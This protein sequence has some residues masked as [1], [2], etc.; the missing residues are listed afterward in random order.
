[1]N[2]Y[3]G[4]NKMTVAETFAVNMRQ[5]RLSLGITQKQLGQMLGYSEKSVSKWESGEA[6][7]PSVL[8]PALAGILRISI[9]DLFYSESEPLYYLGIDGGGTKTEFLLVDKSGAEI[10]SIIL[11]ES[12]PVDVGIS[13]TFEVLEKG[14]Y[15]VC[16][17]VP[18]NKVSVF[19]GVAG[20]ITG[21]NQKK[22]AAFLESFHFCKS[23]NDSDAKNAVVA[24][25]EDANGIAVILG[26]G[27]IAFTQNN[28]TFY[29]TGGFGYLFD[30]GGSGY[31]I[32]RDAIL[33][34]LRAEEQGREETVLSVKLKEHYKTDSLLGH[35]SELYE[36]S[37]KY[38]ASAV[39]VVFDAFN[40]GDETALEILERNFEAVSQLIVDASRD[41]EGENVRVC[42]VG[43]LS[44]NKCVVTMIDKH[45][46]ALANGRKFNISVCTKPPVMGALRLA[47]YKEKMKNA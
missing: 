13:K 3:E 23:A 25:L 37:K 30:T 21:D 5:R 4:R 10:K 32:G 7:P 42:L 31:S 16:Q 24:A 40:E 27:D 14:I 8:L 17:G 34:C 43:S 44:K 11:G 18:L 12:N 1:M 33:S 19:A 41:I 35:L 20:G 22:I 39:C 6:V 38:I 36:G 15:E 46:D 28:G 29:R 2:V 26:T 45:L 9:D 47:G